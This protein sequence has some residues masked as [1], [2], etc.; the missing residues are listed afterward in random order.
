[1]TENSVF[2]SVFFLFLKMKISETIWYLM[3]SFRFCVENHQKSLISIS[4]NLYPFELSVYMITHNDEN[5]TKKT[6]KICSKHAQIPTIAEEERSMWM[7]T[8]LD[9]NWLQ[10]TRRMKRVTV[11][12]YWIAFLFHRCV[13]FNCSI[14]HICLAQNTC[15]LCFACF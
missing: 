14:I 6:K 8:G 12:S 9:P 11:S 5:E 7:L 15:P 10:Y 1:M 2:S 4:K 3:C 13:L